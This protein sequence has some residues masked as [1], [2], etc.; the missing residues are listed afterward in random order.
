[1]TE[2][3]ERERRRDGEKEQRQSARGVKRDACK[4]RSADLTADAQQ[5]WAMIDSPC[6]RRSERESEERGSRRRESAAAATTT[7]AAA[8]RLSRCRV[9]PDEG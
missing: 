6:I 7:V 8:T 2:A 1:M 9:D 3:R 5:E 4:T